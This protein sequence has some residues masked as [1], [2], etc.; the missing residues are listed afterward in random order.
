MATS[1]KLV[2]SGRDVGG[3]RIRMTGVQ[4]DVERKRVE[5]KVNK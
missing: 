3:R 1:R 5:W 2:V 4:A